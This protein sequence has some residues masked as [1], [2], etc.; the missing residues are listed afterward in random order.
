MQETSNHKLCYLLSESINLTSPIFHIQLS[1]SRKSQSRLGT[2]TVQQF[3]FHF[4]T[5]TWCRLSVLLNGEVK[6]ELLRVRVGMVASE[7][8]PSLG[9][10]LD[11]CNWA[12]ATEPLRPTN[13]TSTSSLSLHICTQ[14]NGN[15]SDIHALVQNYNKHMDGAKA[16]RVT[17]PF[18]TTHTLQKIVVA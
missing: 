14:S 6:G 1:P 8:P 3:F 10:N 18:A 7:V 2:F 9:S 11:F 5:Q 12:P 13:H 16:P 4:H 15:I 17:N